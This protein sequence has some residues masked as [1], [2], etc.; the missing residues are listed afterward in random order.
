MIG[1]RLY[2][3]DQIKKLI[4]ANPATRAKVAA[5]ITA[6][7]KAKSDLNIDYPL[8]FFTRII[9]GELHTPDITNETKLYGI[10]SGKEGVRINLDCSKSEIIYTVLHECYHAYQKD[11]YPDIYGHQGKGI[12]EMLEQT[13]DDYAG[14]RVKD[15]FS[16]S[17]YQNGKTE[18][19]YYTATYELLEPGRSC[20][21][22]KAK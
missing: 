22:I 4:D 18:S 3:K 13:A 7:E 17:Q 1:Y 19:E 8:R 5:G 11:N 14:Q 2:S 16:G 20:A 12:G 15:W 21:T 9:P 6:W 10:F